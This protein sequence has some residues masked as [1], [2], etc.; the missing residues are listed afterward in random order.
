MESLI[1]VARNLGLENKD[2]KA[3]TFQIEK[4][5]LQIMDMHSLSYSDIVNVALE[6]YLREK[7]FLTEESIK[8]LS[9]ISI[10]EKTISEGNLLTEMC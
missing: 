4:F 5:I 10:L 2:R 9:S 8:T 6:K 3:K 7:G 1:T